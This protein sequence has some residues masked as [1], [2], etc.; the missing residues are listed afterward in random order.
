MLDMVQKGY[1]TLLP[2]SELEHFVHLKLLPAG[3]IPQRMRRPWPIM[4]YTFTE[5]NSSS[6]PLSPLSSMQFGQTLQRL[7]QRIAYADPSH[8]PPLLLKLDLS[9]G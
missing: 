5:I 8:G 3:V 4:D 9:D 1:W 6:V 2:F 7:L